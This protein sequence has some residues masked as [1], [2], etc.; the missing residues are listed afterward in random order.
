MVALEELM[1]I[2]WNL[3]KV[4]LVLALAIPLSIIVF[5]TAL[6]LVGALVGIAFAVLKLAVLGLV[7]YGVFR[8]G[9]ALLGG[10]R[11]KHKPQEIGHLPPVDPYYKAAMRELDR[12]LGEA[13]R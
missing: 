5:G 2:L 8:V 12:D 1:R 4:A 13:Q 9:A 7:C 10:S 11:S 6:G 3:I